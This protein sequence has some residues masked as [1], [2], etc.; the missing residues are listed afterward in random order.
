[1]IKTVAKEID[2]NELGEE[3]EREISVRFHYSLPMMRLYEQMYERN[4]FD[5]FSKIFAKF[6]GTAKEKEVVEILESAGSREMQEFLIDVLPCM[7]IEI[8]NGK[9]V[10]NEET[11]EKANLSNWLLGFVNPAF[12]IQVV[13]ELSRNQSKSALKKKRGKSKVKICSKE[14]YRGIFGLRIDAFWAEQQH[15]N[16]LL[17]VLECIANGSNSEKPKKATAAELFSAVKLDFTKK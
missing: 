12:F 5:D 2:F 10:Q 11:Y 1:M 13:H 14:I 4:F 7:Y 9:I 17:A 3:T 15:L 8:E 6:S 16:Y